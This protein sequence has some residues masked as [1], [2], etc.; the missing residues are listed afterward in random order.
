MSF[1]KGKLIQ[2]C[3]MKTIATII[4]KRNHSLVAKIGNNTRMSTTIVLNILWDD[5]QNEI[6]QEKEIK[7]SLLERRS[8][9]V[10]IQ[11]QYGIYVENYKEFTT[12]PKKKKEGKRKEIATECLILASNCLKN[13]LKKHTI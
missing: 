10:S 8:R 2:T 1:V 12:P 6:R 5:L 13:K 4:L 9:T 7:V 3:M 11:R